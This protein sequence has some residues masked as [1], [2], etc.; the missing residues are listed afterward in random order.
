MKKTIYIV[1]A[2]IIA[3]IAVVGY[4]RFVAGG[5][6][7]T[8]I[9]E[10]GAWVKHG[11]P[12]AAKPTTACPGSGG[13]TN[14]GVVKPSENFSQ[15]PLENAFGWLG[16]GEDGTDMGFIRQSGGGWMR[17]HPG[18]AVWDM[19]QGG[20][21]AEYDFAKM[22]GLVRLAELYGL[23]LVI[24]LW[25][26]AE[27]DQA[28]REDV[29]DCAVSANDEFLP[30]N[31]KKGRPSYL[32]LHRCN[33][34]D[35]VAYEQF[36]TAVV[37]RYDGDGEFDMNDLRYPI[38]YWEVMN[39]PDLLGDGSLD[40]YAQGPAEY[41]ELLKRTYQAVKL[42]DSSASVLIA[43][44]AGA[45]DTFLGFY[46]AVFNAMPEAKG[47]FDIAN[48]HCI[49]NDKNTLDFNVGDY[50]ALLDELG[51][52]KPIWVTEAEQMGRQGF[53]Q[54]AEQTQ[55]SVDNAIAA[56]AQKIFFTRYDF[57]DTRTDMSEKQ[58]PAEGSMDR[59]MQAY[60]E[61]IESVQ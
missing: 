45:D 2:V 26:F 14:K 55:T 12:S 52:N 44:A 57:A 46:R 10:K 58:E 59:S 50:K 51:I 22:D 28:N 32:P 40:F 21:P 37:D 60:Q 56:G 9:C 35:W 31:N 27:W 30:D 53:D 38:K 7:D 54:N 39:E 19:I 16:A 18:P 15:V 49:S 41:A 8:W 34:N 48:I 61:I 11:N 17:P 1:I 24:T 3:A 33:P 4:L 36:V 47:Y 29:A 20:E 43:G 13:T 5:D 25:P 42:A 6:E 23:N